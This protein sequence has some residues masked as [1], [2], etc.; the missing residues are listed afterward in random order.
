MRYRFRTGS[1]GP[2][3]IQTAE[4]DGPGGPAPRITIRC[5]AS[6]SAVWSWSRLPI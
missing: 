4:D 3:G 1:L 2:Q 5:P 6:R